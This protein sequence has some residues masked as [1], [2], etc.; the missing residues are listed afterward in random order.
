MELVLG[1]S[2]KKAI[3]D[4]DDYSLVSKYNW[5][6]QKRDR[7]SYVRGRVVVG[8]IKKVVSLHR[9]IM[10]VTEKSW[11]EI[12][13]DHI[14][15][16]GLDC[17]KENLRLC[18][19]TGNQRNTR[20]R[21]IL[22]SKY[23]GVCWSKGR[24]LFEANIWL[25]YKKINLGYYSNEEEA[26]RSY[27]LNAIFL[28]KDYVNTNFS[29]QEYAEYINSDEKEKHVHRNVTNALS[30]YKR[31]KSS[32]YTG[33]HKNGKHYISY[34]HID[35]KKYHIGCSTDET[36][37]AKKFDRCAIFLGKDNSILNFDR[38]SYPEKIDPDT[39]PEKIRSLKCSD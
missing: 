3:V 29:I 27:D 9:L 38:N 1:N 33:V 39:L 20:K 4:D 23:K 12:Q 14:N 31:E 15:H 21:K 2:E 35:F 13:V 17:R 32:K 30:G 36:E 16:N 18:S 10:G 37:A 8:G 28:F 22:S 11:K 7:S 26:A 19:A 5:Y 34:I 25:D 6:I 24:E